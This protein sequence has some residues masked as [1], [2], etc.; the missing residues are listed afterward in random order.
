M[1]LHKA[2]GSIDVTLVNSITIL[3][4][5][6]AL[7]LLLAHVRGL[8]V[9]TEFIINYVL[10]LVSIGGLE[11]LDGEDRLQVWRGSL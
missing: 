11:L 5:D 2:S 9:F 7:Q 4:K 10:Q 6:D 1:H 3:S 8:V